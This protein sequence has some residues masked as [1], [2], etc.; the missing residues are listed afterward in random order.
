M[1]FIRILG[2]FTILSISCSAHAGIIYSGI[3]NISH[4][5]AQ[6]GV[7][8]LKYIDLAGDTANTWDNLQFSIYYDDYA[9]WGYQTS[10]SGNPAV[11]AY[12]SS[13]QNIERYEAGQEMTGSFGS[14]TRQFF[15]YTQDAF[16]NVTEQGLFKN[17]TGFAGL[18]LGDFG[19]PKYFGWMQFSIE[20]YG[21]SSIGGGPTITIVDW[22]FSDV[23]DTKITVGDRGT[24]I[25]EPSTLSLVFLSLISVL[26][27]RKRSLKR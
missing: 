2:F 17:G 24:Q 4:T 8:D 25:S 23:A 7:L 15:S 12:E 22:A 20:N 27:L 6:E 9:M 11:L 1:K 14:G 13:S 19:G 10:W 5:P 3:Q 18:M 26:G 21:A 16:G